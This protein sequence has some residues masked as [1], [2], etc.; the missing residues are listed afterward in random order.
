VKRQE[1]S[2]K[3]RRATNHRPGTPEL[4]AALSVASHDV[5]E[6][7][8]VVSGYLEL[9]EGHVEGGLDET[10]GRYVT[11]VRH[12]ID[13]LDALLTGVLAYVRVNVETPRLE[14]ID[15]AECLEDALRPL[16]AA[17]E[18]RQA[19]IEFG[20]LPELLA[21]AGR[22][23]DLLRA[24]ITNA[25][26]FAS[27]EPLVIAVTAERDAGGWR[28]DV[29]DNGIGMPE[30]ARERVLEPFERAHP[31]S[32]A[33][34]PGLGLAIARCVVERRDG[35]LWLEGAEGGGTVVRFTIPD[36]VPAP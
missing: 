21:D 34:G 26:A 16:R 6:A 22:T 8:R 35:R 13:H 24:L 32:Q 2:T 3:P 11:G 1:A 7:L 14:R 23:R 19:R 30:D 25:L 29:R 5:A 12:G 18:E 17:L 27:D 33:T 4:P 10:A 31:R 20:D 15:L 36:E 28:I 9:L